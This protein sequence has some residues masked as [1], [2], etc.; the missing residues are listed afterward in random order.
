MRCR[1]LS[2]DFNEVCVNGDCPYC[3]E[4]CPVTE[5]PEVCRFV[6]VRET[7]S[8]SKRENNAQ[9]EVQLTPL[10]WVMETL[11]QIDS[12]TAAQDDDGGG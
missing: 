5:H 11:R 1:W 10:G 7:T 9:P 3:A 12:A 6:E 8:S 4:W 2:D